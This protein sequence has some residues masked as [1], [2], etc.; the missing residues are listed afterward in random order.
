MEN[1]FYRDH[2]EQLLKD[3][4]DNFRMY[5]SRRVWHSIYN[6]LHPGKKWPSVAVLLLLMFSIMYIGVTNTEYPSVT[7][8]Q[9]TPVV[10]AIQMPAEKQ[11]SFSETGLVSQQ[12]E[13]F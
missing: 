3:T 7:A 12:N 6:D 1:N 9:S 4:T 13:T 2:F 5:P 11:I 8:V 10:Y